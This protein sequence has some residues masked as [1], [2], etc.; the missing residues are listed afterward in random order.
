[1]ATLN[2][3]AQALHGAVDG[4]GSIEITH[5]CE[6]TAGGPGGLTFL[7]DV[8]YSEFL[9]STEASAVILDRQVDAQ[10]KPAIR[11]DNPA[12][13][14]A[15]ATALL[16]PQ[17]VY[18]QGIHPTAILG[19]GV[20]LAEDVG[21]GPYVAIGEDVTI[22]PE[23]VIEA[24]TVIGPGARLGARVHLYPRVV[25]YAGVQVADDVIIHSGTVIGSDG[26]G[27]ITEGDSH[28]KIPHVGRVVI[29][30]RV[31]I[32]ANCAIDR[33]TLGDT[34]IGEDTKIDNLVH[35]AHNVKIGKGCFLAGETGIGGSTVIGD[36]VT[37]A[38]Q[39]GVA[40]HLHIAA[41][42]VVAGKAA[43]R[44]SIDQPQVYAGDP[45]QPR[46]HWARQSMVARKLPELAKRV[47]QLEER[48]EQAELRKS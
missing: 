25:L 16:Q 26:F 29:G 39:V 40:D 44:Q 36:H 10:G 28:Y 20:Q 42:T 14:F 43:V 13:A 45:A 24:G 48:L 30:C 4:D 27:Y 18:P 32:G 37:L 35:V 12:K 7:G 5:V 15:E 23:S 34:V 19:G 21:I 33:G 6:I 47:S 1:L 41:G 9:A 11:V 46:T 8:R 22:G 38:A 17:A 2:Q 31:E 3:I